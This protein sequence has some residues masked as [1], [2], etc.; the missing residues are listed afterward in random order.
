MKYK[1]IEKGVAAPKGFLASGVHSGIRNN[2]DKND[3]S[4]IY[5]EKPCFAAAVFTEN[6]AKAA[7]VLVTQKNISDGKAQAIIANSKN[8]NAC[9]ID[10]IEK[11]QS[12]CTL[13]AREL[14]ISEE[15]VLVA[16]TGI[17]GQTLPIE[18]IKKSIPKLVSALSKD[19]SNQ[20]ALGIM[21]TDLIP[22][23]LAIEFLIAGKKVR[24]GAIAKG[25]GMIH[26]NMATMLSFVTTDISITEAML[27]MA[28]Q[29]VTRDTFNMISIDGDTSTNDTFA[30]M[31]SGEAGNPEIGKADSDYCAFRDALR[32]VCDLLSR[33][34]A[35]DG[36]GATKLLICETVNAADKESAK[37]VAKCVIG[38]SLVKSAM[39]GN[40]ANWG[41]VLAAVGYSGADIYI[42]RV[43]IAFIS[44]KGRIE[45]CKGGVGIGFDEDKALEI[46]KE[47]E[48]TILVNLND[49]DQAA[50]AYGCDLTYEYVKINGDYRT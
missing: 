19:G 3:L 47:R 4:L 5:C 15:D 41:R 49:K 33:E 43:D 25:S 35:K 50:R 11:A 1:H 30:V 44:P 17:I 29:D 23:E 10:G 18:P 39:F 21:T 27:R 32:Y 9:T 26:P 37:R 13:V 46:L 2:A 31:A 7:P 14:G 45:V 6:L 36:E 8:A 12:M 28:I 38:S 42:D 34:M 20:A 48:I 40:D 16:S 22:K 24:I